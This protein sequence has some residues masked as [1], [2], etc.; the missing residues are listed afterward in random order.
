M[1]NIETIIKTAKALFDLHLV[2]A[3]SGELSIREGDRIFI[4]RK[5]APLMALTEKDI[6]EAGMEP[7]EGDK[8]ISDELPVHRAIYRE[9]QGTAILH[10]FPA[11]AV[12]LSMSIEN[13][14]MPQD[15]RGQTQLRSIPVVRARTYPLNT[16][17]EE[18]AKY[19]PPIY[20]S[21]YMISVVK[22]FGSYAV[23]GS[24]LDALELTICAEESCRILAVNKSFAVTEKQH[25]PPEHEKRR[26]AIPPSIGVMDRQPHYKRG[27]GR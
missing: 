7:S 22:E 5:G 17:I 10:A 9:T 14:I 1:A 16:R 20:K 3:T 23:S 26:S 6:A 19:L 13:K 2:G 21:G 15:S 12:A 24:L 8:E 27:F 4:T 25:R 11:T 18:L